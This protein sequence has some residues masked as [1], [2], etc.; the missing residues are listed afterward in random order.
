MTWPQ[1]FGSLAIVAFLLWFGFH[2]WDDIKACCRERLVC[3]LLD[4]GTEVGAGSVLANSSRGVDGN[5]D[6]LGVGTFPREWPLART[7]P[8]DQETA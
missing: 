6:R 5:D 3:E 4:D 8:Y 1:Y 7:G 2:I